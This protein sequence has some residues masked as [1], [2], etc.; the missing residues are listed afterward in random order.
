M[1]E[2]IT[3][4]QI[5]E[6]FESE[7]KDV[8]LSKIDE[9]FFERVKKYLET[10]ERAYEETKNE[11]I[12]QEI[13]TTR[14]MVDEIFNTRLKKLIN[15]VFI[16]LKTGVLPENMLKVEEEIFFKLIDVIKEFKKKV[17]IEKSIVKVKMNFDIPSFVGPDGKTYGPYK[18]DEIV[19]LDEIIANYLIL[20]N[21]AT[22]I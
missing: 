19:E 1:E 6:V 16:F 22:K 18:K 9:S 7:K 15:S 21:F 12:L 20:N 11:K 8:K 5:R 4:D 10:K 2:V 13:K 17:K 3:F 14:R